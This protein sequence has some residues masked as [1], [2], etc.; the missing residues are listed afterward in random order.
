MQDKKQLGSYKK[1]IIKE[2]ELIRQLQMV[3]EEMKMMIEKKA[4]K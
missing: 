2:K 1:L 3:R 4:K